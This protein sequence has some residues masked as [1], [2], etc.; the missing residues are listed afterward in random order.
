MINR[1][2]V[3]VARRSELAAAIF[4]IA[5]VALPFQSNAA[6]VQ[7]AGSQPTSQSHVAGVNG[8]PLPG[9]MHHYP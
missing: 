6:V 8:D 5:S 2:Q 4:V 7:V 1:L 3:L 9:I